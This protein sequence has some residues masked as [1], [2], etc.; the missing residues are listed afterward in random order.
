M[1]NHN[2]AIFGLSP[3]LPGLG[4]G[5][6]LV[7]GAEA[8][9][10]RGAHE[11][12]LQDAAVPREAELRGP[13]A[14]VAPRVPA[15]SDLVGRREAGLARPHVQVTSG[16]GL[17]AVC[18]RHELV[19]LGPAP[20][21]GRGGVEDE[22]GVVRLA[23]GDDAAAG[24]GHAAH[25]THDAHGVLDVLEE[26]VAVDD[27]ERV[28][29][30]GEIVA[31]DGLE[32]HVVETPRGGVGGGLLEDGR[33]GVTSCDAPLGHEGRE[34]CGDG[35]RPTAQV[36]DLVVWFDV[37]DEER[38]RVIRRAAGV[39]VHN[40]AVVAMRVGR[41]LFFGCHCDLYCDEV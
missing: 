23:D 27:V 3:L 32:G 9:A 24:F 19:Q 25:L 15:R 12:R 35:A 10:H 2:H 17:A 11:P 18:P 16:V 14:G 4:E 28:V 8:L 20:D 1:R 37:R 6:D 34:V 22:A 31:V 29:G 36:Q 7:L 13:L 40:R 38:R 33:D 26:L 21:L 41:L 5:P 39:I 30:E